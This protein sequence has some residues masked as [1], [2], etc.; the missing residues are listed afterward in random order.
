MCAT[1]IGIVLI[2]ENLT[3]KRTSLQFLAMANCIMNAYGN[4][5]QDE[6]NHAMHFNMF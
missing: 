2:F 5:R 3:V 4:L 1:A 6:A